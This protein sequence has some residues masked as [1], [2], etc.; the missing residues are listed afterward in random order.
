[1]DTTKHPPGHI[2]DTTKI[3]LETER[4]ASAVANLWQLYSHDPTVYAFLHGWQ[5][6]HFR[7]FEEMLCEL[8]AQLAHEKAE[9]AK[10]AIDAA[11]GQVPQI[12]IK[13]CPPWTSIK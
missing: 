2:V 1:M 5:F 13:E 4:K 8:A 11:S 12:I 3:R 9:F 7:S 10:A 6:G